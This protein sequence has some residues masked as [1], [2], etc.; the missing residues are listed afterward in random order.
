MRN[1]GS[2]WENIGNLSIIET[3]AEKKRMESMNHKTYEAFRDG[4]LSGAETIREHAGRVHL[5]TPWTYRK[6]MGAAFVSR[7]WLVGLVVFSS[8][9]AVLT[10]YFYL[11]KRKQV[12]DHYNMAPEEK[13]KSWEAVEEAMGR[14]PAPVGEYAARGKA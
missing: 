12:A 11:R 3:R 1:L 2:D 6:P 4:L 9:L 14:N 5:R 8:V 13:G 10:A 7:P